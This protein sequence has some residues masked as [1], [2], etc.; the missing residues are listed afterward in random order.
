MADDDKIVFIC[1]TKICP[2]KEKAAGK[3]GGVISGGK[4]TGGN[5]TDDEIEFLGMKRDESDDI[6]Y[7]ATHLPCQGIMVEGTNIHYNVYHS[8]D[9][10]PQ[11]EIGDIGDLFVL[12]RGLQGPV[13]FWKKWKAS[14]KTAWKV[15]RR[16]DVVR[17]PQD[18]RLTLQAGLLKPEWQWE[19]QALY[20]DGNF[21]RAALSFTNI[22]E[23]GSTPQNPIENIL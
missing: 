7:W 14:G 5:T 3:K 13:V 16:K 2:D 9:M 19:Y 12:R 20:S 4:G 15:A 6:L 21:T 18:D 1:M 8:S 17:H 23:K 10:R 11:D 22:Y